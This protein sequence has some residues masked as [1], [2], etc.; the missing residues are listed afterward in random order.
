MAIVMPK[1]VEQLVG[2]KKQSWEK[3]G[4]KNYDGNGNSIGIT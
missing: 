1:A 4:R 3:E 2:K